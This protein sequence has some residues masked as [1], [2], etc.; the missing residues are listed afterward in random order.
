MDIWEFLSDPNTQKTLSWLGGGLVVLAGG[1]W[2]VIKL[3]VARGNADA[4]DRPSVEVLADRGGIAAGG[5]VNIQSGLS[6]WQVA[7]IVLGVAGA[8]LLGAGLAGNRIETN[9]SIVTNGDVTNSNITI[10]GLTDPQILEMLR[11]ILSGQVIS[12]ELQAEKDLLQSELNVTNEALAAYFGRLGRDSVPPEK[13][14][15]TLIEYAKRSQDALKRID[16]L[17]GTN[18][19]IQDLRDRAKQAVAEARFE[20]ADILLARAEAIEDEALQEARE[21]VDAI[22]LRKAAIRAAR[23]DAALA[24]LEFRTAAEHFEV[25]ASVVPPSRIE[26]RLLYLR[27]MAG[28]LRDQGAKKGD[29]TALIEAIDTSRSLLELVPRDRVPL[30]WAR[31]QNNLGNALRLLGELESG[32]ARLEE[33]VAAYRASLEE[34]PRD[35]W[36]LGWA[37]INRGLAHA[38]EELGDRRD[39]TEIMLQALARMRVA[40]DVYRE[41][42]VSYWLLVSERSIASIDAW[43]KNKGQPDG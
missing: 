29:K 41:G 15:E 34:L 12:A 30:E 9:N 3:F 8:V 1:I 42:D 13:L 10:N 22:A 24:A 39:D 37:H 21:Q 16:L 32:T 4:D 27:Q 6:G 11:T 43:L 18:P 35:R 26:H 31:T 5:N 23:G 36:P 33:A 40:A 2:A 20:D 7:L 28:A 17:D 19:K 38:L 25:A 14:K